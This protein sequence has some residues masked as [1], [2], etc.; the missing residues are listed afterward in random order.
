[1]SVSCWNKDTTDW[2][3]C[4]HQTFISQSSG[5]GKSRIKVPAGLVCGESP[6]AGFQKTISHLMGER[7]NQLSLFSYRIGIPSWGPHPH[8]L[9]TS[10]RP[11][12]LIPSSWGLA[13]QRMNL[14]GHTHSVHSTRVG[15]FVSNVAIWDVKVIH[16]ILMW[17]LAPVFGVDLTIR[18][19]K[20]HNRQKRDKSIHSRLKYLFSQSKNSY[21]A[22]LCAKD[23]SHHHGCVT[24]VNLILTE[25][26][27]WHLV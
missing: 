8:D 7:G 1:M 22:P 17:F 18:L 9:I 24:Q 3:P 27:V 4:K 15:E 11:Q 16:I 2:V 12:L 13:F 5:G 21:R 6:L 19:N 25:L 26:T 20:S 14:E 23:D 10:Q